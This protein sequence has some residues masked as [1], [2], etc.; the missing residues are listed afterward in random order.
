MNSTLFSKIGKF[1]VFLGLIVFLVSM[2]GCGG[3]EENIPKEQVPIFTQINNRSDFSP[4]DD[5]DWAKVNENTYDSEAPIEFKTTQGNWV[6]FDGASESDDNG[7]QGYHIWNI[8]GLEYAIGNNFDFLE[9]E[10]FARTYWGKSSHISLEFSSPIRALGAQFQPRAGTQ[11]KVEG[12]VYNSSNI[13]VGTVE[14]AYL[15]NGL[16]NGSAPF[17]GFR[18]KDS[19]IKRVVFTLTDNS[20]LNEVFSNEVWMNRVDIE[21]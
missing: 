16:R 14:G 21:N 17:L 20:N 19:N 13:L 1:L 8:S 18:N 9:D 11:F 12:R 6:K 7:F 3:S 15:V 2:L 4:T 10:L 5:I